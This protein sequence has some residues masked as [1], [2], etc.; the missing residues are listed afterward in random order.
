MGPVKFN[1]LPWDDSLR[2]FFRKQVMH[3]ESSPDFVAAFRC[4]NSSVKTSARKTNL[5]KV[6]NSWLI[7]CE[8][9]HDY[10]LNTIHPNQKKTE[11]RW[12][13]T[14]L[15][16]LQPACHCTDATKTEKMKSGSSA[17]NFKCLRMEPTR[18]KNTRWLEMLQ[19]YIYIYYTNFVL[20]ASN[21]LL[22]PLAGLDW[23]QIS[24]RR[25]IVQQRFQSW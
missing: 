10:C 18:T 4:R 19:I 15:P 25:N 12:T 21:L 20:C 23:H 7:F 8:K 3:P 24:L 5:S 6:V 1:W 2:W 13:K 14:F 9:W 16:L 22:A 11:N 17:G